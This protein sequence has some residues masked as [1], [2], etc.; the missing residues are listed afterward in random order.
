MPIHIAE[1]TEQL[2]TVS[3]SLLIFFTATGMINMETKTKAIDIT[4]KCESTSRLLEQHIFIEDFINC[5]L[6]LGK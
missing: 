3:L 5:F 4:M 6:Q 1:Y 2:Y